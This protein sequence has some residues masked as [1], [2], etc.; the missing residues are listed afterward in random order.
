MNVSAPDNSESLLP[1]IAS[2]SMMVYPNPATQDKCYIDLVD[3]KNDITIIITDINGK[4]EYINYLPFA[5]TVALNISNLAKGFY[6]VVAQFN[7]GKKKG[8][9]LLSK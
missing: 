6:I 8:N 9:Y 7:G 2:P 3:T 5:K 4:Q 1:G